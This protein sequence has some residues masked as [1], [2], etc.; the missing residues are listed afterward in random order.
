M[1]TWWIIRIRNVPVILSDIYKEQG[2]Q[3]SAIGP[4]W[5]YKEAMGM[6]FRWSK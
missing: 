3:K 5:T 1:R 6:L 4:Y 2:E